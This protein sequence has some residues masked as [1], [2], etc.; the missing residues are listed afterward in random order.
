MAEYI[1]REALLNRV[2]TLTNRITPIEENRDMFYHDSGWNGAIVRARIEIGKIPAADVV[3]VV[4]CKYCVN[5]V[6]FDTN[7]F[8]CEITGYYCGETGY[9]SDGVRKQK[10]RSDNQCQQ[11]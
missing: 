7:K 10:E 5:R 9:C 6:Q 1:E 4:R 8:H 3:E 11:E 2:K